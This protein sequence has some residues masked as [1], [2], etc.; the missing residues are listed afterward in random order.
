MYA[1]HHTFTFTTRIAADA[2]LDDVVPLMS[3]MPGFVTGYWV[4]RSADEGL[5]LVVFNSEAAAQDFANWLKTGPDPGVRL[6][7]ESIV[8]AEVLARALSSD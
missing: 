4:A 3:A 1:V 8:V 2:G 7:R 5:A 6:E